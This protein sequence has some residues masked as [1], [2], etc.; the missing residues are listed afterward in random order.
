MGNLCLRRKMTSLYGELA[1]GNTN[2]INELNC[3]AIK[4]QWQL[5][6]IVDLHIYSY[7]AKTQNW[8]ICLPKSMC[9]IVIKVFKNVKAISKCVPSTYHSIDGIDINDCVQTVPCPF[10][11]YKL[12]FSYSSIMPGWIRDTFFNPELERHRLAEH[13]YCENHSARTMRQMKDVHLVEFLD[14]ALKIKNDCCSIW[15]DLRYKSGWI[16]PKIPDFFSLETGLHSSTA[17]RLFMK[18]CKNTVT[19]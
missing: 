8:S 9:T 7:K 6:L 12:G 5:V 13:Q 1:D 16:P 2:K 19:P 4:Q 14:L 15:C 11:M 18:H 3:E 10:S 17:G